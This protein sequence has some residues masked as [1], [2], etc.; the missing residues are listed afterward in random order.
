MFGRS[1]GGVARELWQLQTQLQSIE[2]LRS[3]E[4]NSVQSLWVIEVF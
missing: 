4:I 2:T 3:L 1:L